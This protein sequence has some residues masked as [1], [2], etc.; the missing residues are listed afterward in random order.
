MLLNCYSSS[1]KVLYKER[2]LVIIINI[3]VIS[4]MKQTFS[5]WNSCSYLFT[6]LFTNQS[7][8]S[9]NVFLTSVMF[10]VLD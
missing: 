3:I 9:L 7:A 6:L 10:V 8:S 1:Y 4:G 5:K 2:E